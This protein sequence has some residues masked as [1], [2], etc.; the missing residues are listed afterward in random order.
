MKRASNRFWEET[1]YK[2]LGDKNPCVECLVRPRC[3]K[4][5]MDKTACDEL[6]KNLSEALKNYETKT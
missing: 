1:I 5:I 6:M 4:S 2:L 3:T